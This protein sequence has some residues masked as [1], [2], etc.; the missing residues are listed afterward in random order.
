MRKEA[1]RQKES[2][3]QKNLNV[4]EISELRK[5]LRSI[6]SVPDSG[7][8]DIDIIDSQSIDLIKN[9]SGELSNIEIKLRNGI[10]IRGILG[11]PEKAGKKRKQT[12]AVVCIHGARSL[13]EVI[14]GLKVS[15]EI[16]EIN[17]IYEKNFALEL[18][19]NGYVVF[20]PYIISDF[21]LPGNVRRDLD[22]LSISLGYRLAGIEILKMI[23]SLDFLCEC[24]SV[25]PGRIGIY[26]VSNGGHYALWTA[27]IDE[28]IKVTVLSNS[29]GGSDESLIGKQDTRPRPVY[30]TDHTWRMHSN[31]LEKFDD[32][33]LA[34]MIF[35]GYLFIEVGE[36]DYKSKL[37]SQYVRLIAEKIDKIGMQDHFGYEIAQGKGHEI[38]LNESLSF[39][40]RFI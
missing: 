37:T 21:S 33:I 7:S 13:P 20:A 18:M 26:G 3:W 16:E 10:S 2:R 35:P 23:K 5:E 38:I 27:A 15:K 28:R 34:F 19:K 36:E 12:P 31:Y 17:K 32:C 24:E 25:D 22:M 1:V 40:N 39:I 8:F 30:L 9:I 14:F 29:F 11:I 4:T 6:L